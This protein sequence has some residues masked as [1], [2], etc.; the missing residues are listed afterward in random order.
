MVGSYEP[1]QKLKLR[2]IARRFG[3]SVTPVREALGRLVSEQALV[4]L[5]HRSVS[6]PVMD[7]AH[8]DEVRDLRLQ[9]EGMAA[10][11]AAR[12]A[13]AAE[14][15]ALEAI[16]AR[17]MLGRNRGCATTILRENGLFHLNLCRAAQAE[18]HLQLVET[19]WLQ[20]GPL[21]HGMTRWPVARPKQHPHADVIDALR[22]RDGRS[23]RAAIEQDILMSMAAL[24]AYL[25]SRSDQANA[26]APSC[27]ALS[28][29]V[30]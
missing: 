6:V 3:V 12:A 20:C 26:A 5:D 4:Q 29:P 15:D 17:L 13:C 1:G 9:I 16:H 19:L 7:L 30:G 27:A 11:R 8:F 18:V 25:I 23:A 10:E 28:P 22:R 24:R 2:D 21:M 14:I